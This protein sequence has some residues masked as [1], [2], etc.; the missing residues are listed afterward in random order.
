MRVQLTRAVLLPGSATRRA[1]ALEPIVLED[2]RDRYPLGTCLEILVDTDH[3]W[4]IADVL[5]T[6]IAA[7]FVPSRSEVPNF[8]LSRAAYW[9]RFALR[10]ASAS[11]SKWLLEIQWPVVDRVTFYPPNPAG[12]TLVH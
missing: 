10:N 11:E 2:D 12:G 4:S 3:R 9:V 5:E 7:R 8:G 1:L 6:T